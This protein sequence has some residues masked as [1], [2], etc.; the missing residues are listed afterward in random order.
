M[1][2]TQ[3]ALVIKTQARLTG[4]SGLNRFVGVNTAPNGHRASDAARR[5]RLYRGCRSNSRLGVRSGWLQCEE[6]RQHD[7]WHPNAALHGLLPLML[8]FILKLQGFT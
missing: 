1:S 3:V 8:Q 7:R 4:A 5:L 2:N 6:N